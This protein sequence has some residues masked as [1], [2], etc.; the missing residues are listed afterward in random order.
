MNAINWLCTIDNTMIENIFITW[1][2]DA[3]DK[4][5]ANEPKTPWERTQRQK[6][7]SAM[8]GQINNTSKIYLPFSVNGLWSTMP[9]KRL[10]IEI[11][12]FKKEIFF[13]IFQKTSYNAYIW[14]PFVWGE[15]KAEEIN[16]N[17]YSLWE[18]EI[19]E[20]PSTPTI[21]PDK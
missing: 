6:V 13:K 4:N 5:P 21:T 14:K 11:W 7:Q 12:K 15:K 8:N 18:K 19:Q 10:T 2:R 16:Q 20:E 1:W 17:I 9:L 3:D